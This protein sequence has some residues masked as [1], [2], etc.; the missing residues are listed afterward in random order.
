MIFLWNTGSISPTLFD[1][2]EGIYTV[3]ITDANGCHQVIDFEVMSV[4]GLE[5][6]S[7]DEMEFTY[8]AQFNQIRIEN[9]RGDN[10]EPMEV[11]NSIGKIIYRVELDNDETTK[12]ITLPK[13]PPGVYF[14]WHHVGSEPFKFLVVD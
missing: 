9:W 8:N 10:S 5:G 11:Y 13:M 4:A 7:R 1:L 14:L 3:N 2:N 6:D 12:Y